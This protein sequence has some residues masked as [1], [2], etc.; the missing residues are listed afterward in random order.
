[1]GVFFYEVYVIILLGMFLIKK[2]GLYHDFKVARVMLLA[3]IRTHIQSY[4]CLTIVDIFES[5]VDRMPYQTAIL[6]AETG[7]KLTYHDVRASTCHFSNGAIVGAASKS[8]SRLGNITR[9]KFWGYCCFVH[10]ES[11]RIYNNV[12][13][14]GEN[15]SSHCTN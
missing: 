14:L 6:F 2:W 15:W 10:G 13:W 3:W 7:K 12:A 11:S 1:M 4:K 9:A 5:T 8:S